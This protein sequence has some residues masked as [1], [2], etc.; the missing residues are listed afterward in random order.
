MSTPHCA[1]QLIINIS[2]N[3]MMCNNG[4][5]VFPKGTRRISQVQVPYGD[6]RIFSRIH[7]FHANHDIFVLECGELAQFQV[8]SQFGQIINV[9]L[10]S[11][12]DELTNG[13]IKIDKTGISFHGTL[14]NGCNRKRRFQRDGNFRTQ[15]RRFTSN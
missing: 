15:M 6:Q 10:A 14:W 12:G 4:E 1:R 9:F 11:A 3:F 8:V 13:N 2:W 5:G 7:D